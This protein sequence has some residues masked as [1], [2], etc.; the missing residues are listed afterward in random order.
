MACC[1]FGA[2]TLS[3]TML[4][5]CRLDFYEHIPM[6]SYFKFETFH[7]K[8][9]IYN[10]RLQN[11]GHFIAASTCQH[12]G[13]LW[14]VCCEC[15]WE[16]CVAAAAHCNFFLPI[17][18]VLSPLSWT[19]PPISLGRYVVMEWNVRSE[20]SIMRISMAYMTP[21]SCWI[22]V[23]ITHYNAV[24]MDAIASRITSLPIV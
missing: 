1:L 5:Y 10:Y 15:F 7:S 11:V 18:A 19:V 16:R 8:E 6:K 12:L 14:D 13:Q 22:V 3:E 17:I 21:L 23:S 20:S 2:R 4:Q 9:C 24:I